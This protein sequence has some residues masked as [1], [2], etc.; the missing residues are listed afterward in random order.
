[1]GNARV[2][3]VYI[4]SLSA[5]PDISNT[6]NACDVLGTAEDCSQFLLAV[7]LKYLASFEEDVGHR[8][9]PV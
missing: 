7:F 9:Q 2:L 3:A 1:M 6:T 8:V 4:A 5:Q